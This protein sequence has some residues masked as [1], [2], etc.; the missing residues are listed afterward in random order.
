MRYPKISHVLDKRGLQAMKLT[1]RNV[2]DLVRPADKDDV[3]IWDD[4]LPGFGVRLRGDSKRWL[5]QYRAGGAHQRREILGDTRKVKLEAARKAAR[6]RFAQIELGIDPGAKKKAERIAATAA[7]LTLANVS[8]RYLDAKQGSMRPSTHRD[9]SRY[10]SLHWA[11]LR[12][13]PIA[14]LK[15]ADIAAQLQDIAKTRGPISAARARDNLL[16]MFG[17]ATREGLSDHN[18]AAATNDP[19]RGRPGRD[20][21]LAMA[22]LAAIWRVCQD[23]DF[24]RIVRLLMLTGARRSEIGGLKWS[25]IDFDRGTITIAA[26]RAKNR[27]SLT[28]TLPRVAIDILY[29]VPRRD[30]HENVFGNGSDGFTSWSAATAALNDRIVVSEGKPLVPW[31]LHDLRRSAATHMADDEIGI[32]PHIIEALLNHVSGHKRGVAGIYNRASYPRET[33]TALQLWAEHLTAIV[34]GRKRKVVPLRGLK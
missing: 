2:A 11:P 1:E 10:F 17:W 9:A 8:S 15:R 6:Q 25:D 19:G 7:Q 21:V 32:Q 22:E 4:D 16:A 5:V 20:R 34:E 23:D 28:L 29:E 14:T 33:A 24:G 30:G 18:P 27:R 13:R 12:N 3:V 26:A 31:T